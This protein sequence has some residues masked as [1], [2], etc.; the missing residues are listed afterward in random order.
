EWKAY[1]EYNDHRS[2]VYDYA[3]YTF[4]PYEETVAF[5]NRI[6]IEKKSRARTLMNY[7]YTADDRITP[8]FFGE[9]IASYE[10]EFSTEETVS[11]KVLECVKEYLKRLVS[12][13]FFWQHFAGVFLYGGLLIWYLMKKEWI[14]LLK[15][16]FLLG[17]QGMMWLGLLY[18]GRVPERVIYTLNLMLVVTG[19]L[20][21]LEVYRS[22]RISEQIRKT[23]IAVAVLFLVIISGGQ[24]LKI[25]TENIE[26]HRRNEDVESLKQYCMEHPENFYFNDVTS[27]AFT[28][29]NVRL[30][31]DQPYQ[32]NYMSLGD[33]M[34]YSPLWQEKLDQKGIV[35]VKEA[36]YENEDVYLICDFD[37]GLEYLIKLYDDVECVEVDKVAG[38]SIYQLRCNS[39]N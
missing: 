20:L 1:L 8:E 11:D 15:T 32:M 5:Y 31:Q 2:A 12:G 13:K 30:W 10:Q 35:S 33:W 3:D 38:F 27:L 14:S 22:L 39:G 18:A 7:N 6:G 24:Y 9:Y 17:V 4:H 29:Y 23:G 36:L 26:M 16:L 28:T 34:S 25:R 21:C 19:L 37:K